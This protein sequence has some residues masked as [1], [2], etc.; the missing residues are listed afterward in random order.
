VNGPRP[1]PTRPYPPPLGVR[2][3][4]LA[5]AAMTCGILWFTWIGAVLAVIFG[6]VARRQIGEA[7]GWQ[8]GD[9]M[10]LAG[11]V[12]G[13]SGLAVLLFTVLALATGRVS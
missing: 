5:I 9:G 2:T 13:Y 8:R 1:A 11:M 3:N 10:A 6:H 4:G 12:L 7:R